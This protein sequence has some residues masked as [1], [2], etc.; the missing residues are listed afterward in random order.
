MIKSG[1]KVIWLQA[2]P[3]LV[4]FTRLPMHFG[5]EVSLRRKKNCDEIDV[6]FLEPD[7]IRA[8]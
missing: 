3:S 8:V 5:M 7:W 2:R 1:M 6:L 4:S